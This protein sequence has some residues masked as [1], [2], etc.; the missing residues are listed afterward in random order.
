MVNRRGAVPGAPPHLPPCFSRTVTVAA[1]LVT[2]SS[3]NV[4]Q[5]S[6]ARERRRCWVMM[7]LAIRMTSLCSAARADRGSRQTRADTNAF[8]LG[9][10]KDRGKVSGAPNSAG[11]REELTGEGSGSPLLQTVLSGENQDRDGGHYPGNCWR[12]RGYGRD[13]EGSDQQRDYPAPVQ[14]EALDKL[15]H[16]ASPHPALR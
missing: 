6:S 16:P 10:S 1:A 14:R 8:I 12:H 9:N 15:N 7:R 2:S 4:E 13:R 5:A 3:S 11:A